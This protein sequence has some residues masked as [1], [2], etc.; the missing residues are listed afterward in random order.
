M[1]NLQTYFTPNNRTLL[2]YYGVAN[3]YIEP[4]N[5]LPPFKGKKAFK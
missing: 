1:T 3:K 4:A 5:W 2:Y